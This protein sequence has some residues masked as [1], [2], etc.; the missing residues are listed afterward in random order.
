MEEK[1]RHERRVKHWVPLE[2]KEEEDGNIKEQEEEEEMMK[3]RKMTYNCYY[4]CVIE[5]VIEKETADHLVSVVSG[6]ACLWTD[7][8]VDLGEEYSNHPDLH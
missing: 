6:L 8:H 2:E 3:K 1:D 4:Y 5:R 7:S